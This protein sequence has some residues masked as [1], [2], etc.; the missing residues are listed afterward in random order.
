MLCDVK[1]LVEEVRGHCPSDLAPGDYLIFR[2][3]LIQVPKGKHFCLHALQVVLPFLPAKQRAT[4]DEDWLKQYV[5]VV[6]PDPEGNVLMRLERMENDSP[7]T[8]L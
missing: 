3:G 5:H 2:S 6:C 4:S 8:S 7:Q 1:I